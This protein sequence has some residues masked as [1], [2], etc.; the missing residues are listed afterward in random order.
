MVNS[1]VPNM[2]QTVATASVNGTVNIT[3]I[4][5]HYYAMAS[6]NVE[7]ERDLYLKPSVLI[8][9]VPNA[10]FNADVNL[11]IV[12]KQVFTTGLS[13]R[14]GKNGDSDSIDLLA[15]YSQLILFTWFTIQFLRLII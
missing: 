8:K 7:L 14:M 13:Y 6:A 10:P 11:S 4:K 15:F 3:N 1:S 9:Y 2:N 5:R 12:F